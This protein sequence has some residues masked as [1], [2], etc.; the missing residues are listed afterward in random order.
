MIEDL[1]LEGEFLPTDQKELQALL[2]NKSLR[3]ALKEVLLRRDEIDKLSAC[4]LSRQEGLNEALK[5]QGTAIGITMAIEDL[6]SLGEQN[7][8]ASIDST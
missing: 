2:K 8:S 7:D 5:R 3:R 1:R 4:D 6:F